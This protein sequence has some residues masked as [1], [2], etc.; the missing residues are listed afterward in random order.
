V[1]IVG[2]LDYIRPCFPRTMVRIG[3]DAMDEAKLA[4]RPRM[5][6][7]SIFTRSPMRRTG[8]GGQDAR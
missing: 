8:G 2:E 4:L 7:G 6:K 1:V 3:M 5:M